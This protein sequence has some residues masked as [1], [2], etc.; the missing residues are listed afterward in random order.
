MMKYRV[1]VLRTLKSEETE[2]GKGAIVMLRCTSKPMVNL[3]RKNYLKDNSCLEG[4]IDFLFKFNGIG[5]D[6]NC[7]Y[8][9]P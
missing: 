1:K 9:K 4:D 3:L 7:K 5:E 6:E 8:Y 2:I